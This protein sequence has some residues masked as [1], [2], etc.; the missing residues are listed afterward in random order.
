MPTEKQLKVLRILEA[1]AAGKPSTNVNR[2]DAEEC[3]D[4]G[5]ADTLGNQQ[6]ELTSAGRA[7]LRA[8]RK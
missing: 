1:I 8:T 7:A 6:Y 3:C 4:A 5:W 2:Q